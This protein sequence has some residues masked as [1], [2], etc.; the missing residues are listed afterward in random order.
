MSYR[1]LYY[2]SLYPWT[3]LWFQLTWAWLTQMR[4]VCIS[5]GIP[6]DFVLKNLKSTCWWK[7]TNGWKREYMVTCRQGSENCRKHYDLDS[8]GQQLGEKYVVTSIL[9]EVSTKSNQ[10][11][12]STKSTQYNSIQSKHKLNSIKGQHKVDS[13]Q[14][15]HKVD[16][17]QSKHKVNSMQSKHNF[18]SK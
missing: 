14:S 9:I 2:H 11:N 10:L 8:Y 4:I 13:V 16:S 18:S 15:K 1:W 6:W 5:V 17:V 3:F 7:S 12:V